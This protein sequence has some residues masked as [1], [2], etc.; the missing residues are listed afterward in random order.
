MMGAFC[1]WLMASLSPLFVAVEHSGWCDLLNY[2]VA[3]VM[4]C[5]GIA[6]L[7]AR[8]PGAT[9]WGFFVLIPL[10]LVLMW[11][12]A[13][14]VRTLKSG[15]PLELE[16]PAVLGFAVVLVMSSGDYFGTRYTLPTMLFAAAEI[17]LVAPLS[18]AVPQ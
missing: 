13:A 15:A 3:V 10:V 6:V 17:L 1:C 2:S 5:P 8:R 11:P 12:A 7:G 9:A 18:S 14:S 16:V 4:L